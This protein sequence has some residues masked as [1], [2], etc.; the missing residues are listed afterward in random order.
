VIHLD[1][2]QVKVRGELIYVM[3]KIATHHKFVQVIDIIVLDIP[4]AYGLLLSRYWY[5]K[6]NGYF[7][8]Y[9][10]HLWLPLKGYKNMIIIDRE[11][12]LKHMVI[13]LETMNEP[14]ST[15]FPVLGNYS[16]NSHFR[17]LSPLLSN[18]PLTQNSK[19]VCQ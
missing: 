3:I 4:K 17:N 8:T 15:D 6:L 13:D 1:R 7:I 2:T 14:S 19:M 5:E 12:Y 9:W 18:V 10:A 16:C 11:R